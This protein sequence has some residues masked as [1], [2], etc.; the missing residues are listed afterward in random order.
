MNS[1]R[2]R[3]RRQRKIR[4]AIF[5]ATGV[6][7]LLILLYVA[8]SLYF[9][10]HFLWRTRINGIRVGG[11]T[12]EEAETAISED[13]G[14]YT[15]IV[16][17]RDKRL[18]TI[19][20]SQ[21]GATYKPDGSIKKALL[22]QDSK[23]WIG[24]V[25]SG[26][27]I[28]VN[29]PM[30]YD[31]EKLTETVEG[32]SCFASANITEP[33]D[34]YIVEENG[35]Y[36]V[37]PETLGNRMIPDKVVEEVGAAV[38]AGEGEVYLSDAVYVQPEITAQSPEITGPMGLIEKYSSAQ[39]IY[40]IADYDERLEGDELADMILVDEEYQVSLDEDAIARFVQRLASKYNTYGDE[41]SFKTTKG[42]TIV[43][44]GGDYGW[45]IDKESE[46]EL[47]KENIMAGGTTEREPVY[48]QRAKV[49]GLE[50]I[51]DTYVEIDYTN[52]HLWYYEEGKLKMDTDIVSGNISNGNGSPDGLFKVVYK[53][54]PAVLVG[55][56]YE[57]NV[58]YFIV[59]A[60]NVGIHDASW[61]STFGGD[62]YKTS[63]SHGCINV[64]LS[65]VEELYG[66]IEKDTPV[67]AYYRDKVE[68]SSVSADVSNAYSY[69]EPVEEEPPTDGSGAAP[70]EQ[71]TDESGATPAEQTTDGGAVAQ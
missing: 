15:L 57:S 71:T 55:E 24:A 35:V 43:I 46:A 5:M 41:R 12:A 33:T 16:V 42:D 47:L 36:R 32:L 10:T 54:S 40:R 63:G 59:F 61:R 11:M 7:V 27:R 37:E 45:I 14:D 70:A 28:D 67:V 19:E 18:Y 20:G 38:A 60:Y 51:G 65:A 23:N 53:Q 58:D 48:A 26:N 44:G 30:N 66:M 50:D 31:S 21:I 62:I 69:V 4:N 13:A 39:I 25:F 22:Q 9:G 8:M 49:E 64:P 68:L 1:I 52:Q 34:A 2:Q 29:T 17:D 56:N 3:R 6:A